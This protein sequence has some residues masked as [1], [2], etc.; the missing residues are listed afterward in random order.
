MKTKTTPSSS[1]YSPCN[2]DLAY[3]KTFVLLFK[4]FPYSQ[5]ASEG[6]S[7]DRG[8]EYERPGEKEGVR[9]RCLLDLT[10]FSESSL[11]IKKKQFYSFYL[12]IITKKAQHLRDLIQ[13]LYLLTNVFYCLLLIQYATS[14]FIVLMFNTPLILLILFC[15]YCYKIIISVRISPC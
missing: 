1:L 10:K 12:F 13:K 3:L 14:P 6:S 15:F 2:A 9:Q 8:L 11:S 5:E 4:H 7:E